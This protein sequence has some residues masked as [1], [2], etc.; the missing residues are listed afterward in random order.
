MQIIYLLTAR[1]MPVVAIAAAMSMASPSIANNEQFIATDTS[2][3]ATISKMYQQDVSNQG[4]D[5]PVLAQYSDKD[6]QAAFA[7]E[8]DYFE[9]EQMSCNIGHDILW[10]SQDPDYAQDKQFAITEQGLVKVSLAQGQDIYYEL[11]CAITDEQAECKIADV[12]LDE[13]IYASPTLK[14]YLIKNCA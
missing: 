11:A 4:M 6:L 7:L 13:D 5:Y 3:I 9:R 8:Q 10:N 1:I 2:K 12:M 14:S